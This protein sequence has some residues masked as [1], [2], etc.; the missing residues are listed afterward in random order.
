MTA[1][2]A[3]MNQLAGVQY[4]LRI[5]TEQRRD[6]LGD[7][8]RALGHFR[9]RLIERDRLEDERA[10]Q[11]RTLDTALATIND[12]FVLYD[13][14]DRVVIAQQRLQP[15]VVGGV[16]MHQRIPDRTLA[17]RVGPAELLVAQARGTCQAGNCA[18]K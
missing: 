12:G 16:Q 7:M 2:I 13:R 11:Q 18:S 1:M 6:E 10:R 9:D 17:D 14:Q 4:D 15:D 3:T 5:G 8:G